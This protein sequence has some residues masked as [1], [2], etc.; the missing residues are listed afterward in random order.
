MPVVSSLSRSY[1]WQGVAD[2]LELRRDRQTLPANLQ[3]PACNT[4]QLFV[5]RDDN[6]GGEWVH[7][8]QCDYHGDIVELAATTW[9]LDLWHAAVKLATFPQACAVAAVPTD[10]L[11][12]YLPIVERRRQVD[13]FWQQARSQ[14]GVLEDNDLRDVL[15]K[16]GVVRSLAEPDWKQTAGKLVGVVTREQVE[17]CFKTRKHHR[18]HVLRGPG[19]KYLMAV[20]YYD[21][22]GRVVGFL[23]IGRQG[24]DED[25]LYHSIYPNIVEDGI[26]M[27]PAI[28]GRAK[29]NEVY[30]FT[31][32]Q[33]AMR[34]QMRSL[35]TN[36]Y[37][38]PIVALRPGGNVRSWAALPARQHIIVTPK[39]TS[40]TVRK[41][42]D[43]RSRVSI[44]RQNS[45]DYERTPGHWLKKI[46]RDSSPWRTQLERQ[47]RQVTVEQGEA[48]LLDLGLQ[49]KD[50]CEFIRSCDRGLQQK[51][52][53]LLT[54]QGACREAIYRRYTVLESLAGWSIRQSPICNARIQIDTILKTLDKTY[55]RVTV[56]VGQQELSF[57]EDVNVIRKLGLLAWVADRAAE[58]GVV[59]TFDPQWNK[60]AERVAMILQAP[61]MSTSV[62]RIGW[63]PQLNGFRLQ[64]FNLVCGG[65]VRRDTGTVFADPRLPTR[66]LLPP[67]PVLERTIKTLTRRSRATELFWA[68][69]CG[70]VGHILAP[71]L[72]TK[73]RPLVFQGRA[74]A[75]QG[76]VI[77]GHL[78][79]E[80]YSSNYASVLRRATQ[81]HWPAVLRLP[82]D[83][84]FDPAWLGAASNCLAE[85]PD[86]AELLAVLAG[87]DQ[88]TAPEDCLPLQIEPTELQAILPRYLQD[89]CRRNMAL[90]VPET[91]FEGIL[92]DVIAWLQQ[93]WD[94]N[95]VAAGVRNAYTA[96][97][98]AARAGAFKQ[99]LRGSLTAEPKDDFVL[100]SQTE[101]QQLNHPMGY[102]PDVY[103]LT[104][105]LSAA[106]VLRTDVEQ[107]GYWAVHRDWWQT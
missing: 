15:T 65:D 102:R 60:A 90:V 47:L 94:C 76:R 63:D 29:T 61:K 74:A 19:W 39:I 37:F 99:L 42:R 98:A 34:L 23:F 56:R 26:G 27:L 51:L 52:D 30:H 95:L 85:V 5:Y 8:R 107:S 6:F 100:L 17:Q 87:W 44:Y 46:S 71:C 25:T 106:G 31:D 72:L 28:L 12:D 67:G 84:T 101:T 55:Y 14:L 49:R 2:L 91:D 33:T 82:A 75:A 70:V 66:Y 4:H 80:F 93:T 53:R 35:R 36:R 73:P 89:L 32:L 92:T 88:L 86:G 64:H 21:L 59:V 7:C 13:K 43:L 38:L 58:F 48:L 11:N 16:F 83:R 45:R 103:D 81:H 3:C 1:A 69:F 105:L 20:P 9:K 96:G 104:L 57:V 78:G 50:L 22:P 24:R 18:S 79:C 97:D 10:R 77:A 68:T 40:E 41:S 62:G 54:E